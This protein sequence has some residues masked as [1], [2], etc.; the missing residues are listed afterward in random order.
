M[1]WGFPMLWPHLPPPSPWCL[2]PVILAFRLIPPSE[3]LQQLSLRWAAPSCLC[4]AEPALASRSLSDAIFAGPPGSRCA[5]SFILYSITSF[6]VIT[7]LVSTSKAPG[8]GFP[9]FFA[10]C[11][12]LHSTVHKSRGLGCVPCCV[13]SALHNA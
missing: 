1:I 5:F 8:C 6:I 2:T 12:T 13:Q 9:S 7:A 10:V 11:P 3:P 4:V